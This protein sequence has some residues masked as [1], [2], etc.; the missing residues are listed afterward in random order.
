[1]GFLVAL[2]LCLFF[3]YPPNSI[4]AFLFKISYLALY[5]VDRLF[6][7]YFRRI[8]VSLLLYLICETMRL[9]IVVMLSPLPY[10]TT[11]SPCT[12]R[13]LLMTWLGPAFCRF[14]FCFIEDADLG[15]MEGRLW[16]ESMF[17]D[18]GFVTAVLVW[19]GGTVASRLLC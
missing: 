12:S 9:T 8:V 2:Y 19:F 1:M 10:S 6:C 17:V 14:C 13:T 7:A 11:F 15:G 4:A 3:S 5:S 18:V 16:I